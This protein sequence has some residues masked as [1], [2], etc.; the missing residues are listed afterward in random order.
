[1]RAAAWKEELGTMVGVEWRKLRGCLAPNLIVFTV[2][3]LLNCNALS[4]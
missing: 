2:A 4:L 1:M 3:K